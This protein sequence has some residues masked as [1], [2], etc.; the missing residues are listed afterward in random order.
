MAV[1]ASYKG[2]IKHYEGC[3]DTISAYFNNFRRLVEEFQ[4]EVAVAYC[5]L[6]LEQ[7][8]NR[9]LYGGSRKMRQVHTDIATS[10]LDKQHLTREGFLDL[11]KNVYGKALPDQV[12]QKIK[13]SEKIRDRIIHGKKVEDKD[14]K[15]CLVDILDFSKELEAEVRSIA[16]FSPFGD[17][18][19]L[20]GQS[21][22]LD[23]STSRWVM[24]GLGF[25]TG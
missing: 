7:G 13:F 23:K 8:Y 9:T 25:A 19:G 3:P 16:S 22:S 1:P 2:V 6:K 20:T 12:V 4:Y 5:F 18:R 11:Y 21:K 24:K 17:M 14:A 15:K 10:I